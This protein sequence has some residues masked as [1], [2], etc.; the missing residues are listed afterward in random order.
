MRCKKVETKKLYLPVAAIPIGSA[1][2]FINARRFATYE[3]APMRF[4]FPFFVTRYRTIAA[5]AARVANCDDAAERARAR[6]RVCNR[7]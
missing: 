2:K 6:T 7:R 3:R 1:A 5:A 4:I